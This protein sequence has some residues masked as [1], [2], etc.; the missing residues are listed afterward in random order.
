MKKWRYSRSTRYWYYES[1]RYGLAYVQRIETGYRAYGRQYRAHGRK[2]GDFA[3]L[4][5]AKAFLEKQFPTRKK[6]AR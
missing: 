1:E 2:D 4:R 5:E 3:L 6:V